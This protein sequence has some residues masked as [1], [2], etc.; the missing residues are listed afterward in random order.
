MVLQHW[1]ISA[2]EEKTGIS[3][4]SVLTS[5][6]SKLKELNIKDVLLSFRCKDLY[7]SKTMKLQPH[8]ILFFICSVLCNKMQFARQKHISL[9]HLHFSFSLWSC[10]TCSVTCETD[11]PKDNGSFAGY[12]VA[13]PWG[14]LQV[15]LA[16]WAAG[17]VFVQ[18]EPPD[19]RVHINLSDEGVHV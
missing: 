19:V 15:L 8:F 9:L 4:L 18:V 7:Y 2:E 17:T 16:Q 12:A 13:V 5:P 10:N 1:T 14:L 11:K 3:F 6:T